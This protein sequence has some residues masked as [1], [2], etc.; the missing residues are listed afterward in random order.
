MGPGGPML[1]VVFKALERARGLGVVEYSVSQPTLEQ[2]FISIAREDEEEYKD[3]GHE[4][5]GGD[6][7]GGVGYSNNSS[8]NSSNGSNNSSNSSSRSNSNNR[9]KTR[10][11][12]CLLLHGGLLHNRIRK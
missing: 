4:E 9:N 5:D 1:S 8:N 11:P 2:V 12:I 10:M 3:F 6:G 7:M